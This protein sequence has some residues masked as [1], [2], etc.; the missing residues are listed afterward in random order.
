MHDRLIAGTPEEAADEILRDHQEFGA[1]FIWFRL[2]WPGMD[3]E[4]CLDVI[5]RVGN[6]VL[7]IVR[8]RIGTKSLLDFPVS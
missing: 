4:K 3:F 1:D 6:E 2:Y 5:K 7:P 8:A